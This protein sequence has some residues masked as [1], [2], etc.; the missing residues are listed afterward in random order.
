[1]KDI[2]KITF[3]FENIIKITHEQLL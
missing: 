3:L 1:M 2:I